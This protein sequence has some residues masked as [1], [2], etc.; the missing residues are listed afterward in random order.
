MFQTVIH[1]TGRFYLLLRRLPHQPQGQHCVV[2]ENGA[3]RSLEISRH[4][5]QWNN[6]NSGSAGDPPNVTLLMQP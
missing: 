2:K 4:G 3:C 5:N 6:S 1:V